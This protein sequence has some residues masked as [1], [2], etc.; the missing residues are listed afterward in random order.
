VV[1]AECNPLKLNKPKN[2]ETNR[3]RVTPRKESAFP[4]EANQ[5]SRD[6]SMSETS[7][8]FPSW[9]INNQEEHNLLSNP[10]LTTVATLDKLAQLQ[11]KRR[12]K[13]N[14][15]VCRKEKS[16]KEELT[17]EDLDKRD[18]QRKKSKKLKSNQLKTLNQ[19]K[20]PSS[21]SED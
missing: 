14:L 19:S 3:R 6:L 20:N 1:E 11:L 4:K 2:K 12:T 15:Q 13:T 8:I 18:L 9:V 7:Q 16:K 17:I 5:L 10:R 21:T